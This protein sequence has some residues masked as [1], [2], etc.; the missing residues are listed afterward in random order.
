M[1]TPYFYAD[2][3]FFVRCGLAPEAQTGQ[4]CKDPGLY[5]QRA[6]ADSRYL[7]IDRDTAHLLSR[8]VVMRGRHIG[9]PKSGDC[10]IINNFWL[11]AAAEFLAQPHL[12]T[13]QWLI[14]R[15]V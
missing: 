1:N 5:N 8:N 6:V 14:I 4:T 15:F 2:F 12:M 10:V 11:T 13:L 3:S 7:F 9:V